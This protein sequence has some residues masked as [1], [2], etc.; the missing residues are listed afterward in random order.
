VTPAEILT[1][2]LAVLGMMGAII[3]SAVIVGNR[4]GR[5][6]EQLAQIVKHLDQGEQRM[7]NLDQRISEHETRLG[8]L[9]P[10]R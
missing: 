2:T 10:A 3:A 6:E 9:E 8:R 4:V 7:D 5:M 1:A